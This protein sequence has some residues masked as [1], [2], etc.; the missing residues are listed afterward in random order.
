[1]VLTYLHAEIPTMKMNQVLSTITKKI[2]LF[3]ETITEV[4]CHQAGET[5]GGSQYYSC[6]QMK[7]LVKTFSN[8]CNICL[9]LSIYNCP[10]HYKTNIS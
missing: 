4:L 5:C 1:M 2:K 7:V 8:Y 3:V 9:L 10:F 6:K